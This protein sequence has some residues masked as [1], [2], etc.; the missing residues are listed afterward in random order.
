MTHKP[1]S[2][3]RSPRRTLSRQQVTS[4]DASQFTHYVHTSL[5]SASASG[6]RLRSRHDLSALP[7]ATLQAVDRAPVGL[8]PEVGHIDVVRLEDDE[9]E[10]GESLF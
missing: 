4:V 5:L 7:V 8:R 9:S 3:P 1:K 2:H 6:S 10:V